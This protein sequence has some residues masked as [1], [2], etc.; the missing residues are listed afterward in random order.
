MSAAITFVLG[1]WAWGTAFIGADWDDPTEPRHVAGALVI[2]AII[3][4]S[5]A[6]AAIARRRTVIAVAVVC[7]PLQVWWYVSVAVPIAESMPN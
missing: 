1:Y 5:F 3:A 7:A 2:A 4:S 6:A